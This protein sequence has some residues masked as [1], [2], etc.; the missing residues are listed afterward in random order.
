M[1]FIFRRHLFLLFGL[2]TLGLFYPVA[3]P[4]N[5]G[6]AHAPGGPMRWC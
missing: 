5:T 2:L 4:G 3:A 1:R 6:L